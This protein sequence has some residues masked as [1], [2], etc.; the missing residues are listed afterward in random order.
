MF[1]TYQFLSIIIED[2]NPLSC[3]RSFSQFV[4]LLFILCVFDIYSNLKVFPF[5]S[6]SL[7]IFLSW[8]QIL[9]YI[10]F[11]IL[12]LQY[13]YYT[14]LL[15]FPNILVWKISNKRNRKKNSRKNF[16]INT[17]LYPLLKILR[18]T[19]SRLSLSA[20]CPSY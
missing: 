17:V 2:I 7:G 13:H 18:H 4:I 9:T 12:L 5:D 10:F 14:Y 8:D 6:L 16:T 19:Y 1:E 3:L 15:F 20:P 11:D